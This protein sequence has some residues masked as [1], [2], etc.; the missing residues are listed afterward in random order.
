MARP[1]ACLRIDW[2]ALE[3][4]PRPPRSSGSEKAVGGLE[5]GSSVAVAIP[6]YAPAAEYRFTVAGERPNCR[7]VCAMLATFSLRHATTAAAS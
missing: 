2:G 6:P 4:R 3:E 5:I 1:A 7:A